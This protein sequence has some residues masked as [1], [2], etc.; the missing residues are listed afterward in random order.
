MSDFLKKHPVA[1]PT[2]P[3]VDYVGYE[4]GGY[5]TKAMR[6]MPFAVYL[7]HKFIQQD[8]GFKRAQAGQIANAA[9]QKP[10]SSRLSCCFL[11]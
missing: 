1:R 9:S 7:L 4:E 8:I 2:W 11:G 5:L 3:A 10:A 6:R